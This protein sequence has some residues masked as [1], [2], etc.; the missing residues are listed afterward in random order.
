MSK[1]FQYAGIAAS[2]VLIA[3]GIGAV[4][5]GL[6]GRDRVATELGREQIVGTPDSTIPNQLVNSG[7]EAQAFA[8]V[9][10]KHTLEAT[11]GKTYA[12]M[13]QYIDAS[14]KG[15]SDKAAA[16]KDPKTGAPTSNPAR[17]IWVTETALTTALN[18]AYFAESMATF[19]AAMGGALLLV[20]IGF[21]VISLRLLRQPSTVKADRRK[22]SAAAKPAVGTASQPN[23]TRRYAMTP[24]TTS[25]TIV[26]GYD[27]SPSARAAV[28]HAID[29]A[30]P[31]GRLILV[32]AYQVPAD[33]IG[34]SYY[35]GMVE[36]AAQHAADV[37][38]SLE[39]DCERVLGV[40]HERDISTGAAAPA[41]VRAAEAYRADEIVIGS[42]G[43]GRVRALLGSVAHDVLH[44]ATCPVTVIPE[45]MVDAWTA[46]P[47]EATAA[48]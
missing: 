27:G 47:A 15:T 12:Q 46:T 7:S 32:H 17:Q 42:R 38:D 34:A 20:G 25:R 30:G 40:D 26:V 45:R 33:Y 37:M 43:V 22:R 24:E 4:V 8:K 16:G 48:V 5:I 23:R 1:L 19:V 29:R 9:I 3:F 14:G 18:T 2:V 31:A 11:G 28:E 44:R 21:L 6:D 39:R 41:I 13:P 35:S 36:D 10:R